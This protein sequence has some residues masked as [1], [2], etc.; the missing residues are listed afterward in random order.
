M[1]GRSRVFVGPPVA[2]TLASRFAVDSAVE[3][4]SSSSRGWWLTLATLV[5]LRSNS[6]RD[7]IAV[8]LKRAWPGRMDC[9]R[10]ARFSSIFSMDVG[11]VCGS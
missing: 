4:A 1:T 6:C 9:R 7:A 3:V 11:R 5:G 8:S 10:T 2:P